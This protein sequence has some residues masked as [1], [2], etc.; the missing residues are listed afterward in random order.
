MF[1]LHLTFV[2]SCIVSIN[3]ND[4]QQDATILAYLFIP[5]QLYMFR[6]MSSPIIR[7]TGLYLQLLI[8]S[9]GIAAGWCHR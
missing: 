4:D 9:T 3:V 2:C 8:L 5:N 6:A 1:T 7:S